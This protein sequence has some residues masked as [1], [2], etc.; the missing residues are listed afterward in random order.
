MDR[1]RG[2]LG[3][4]GKPRG[5]LELERPR[6]VCESLLRLWMFRLARAKETI[7]GWPPLYDEGPAFRRIPR[8]AFLRARRL[9]RRTPSYGYALMY[10]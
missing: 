1:P 7:C 3:D 10:R 9:A 8:Q 4:A 2:G 6:A 5:Q